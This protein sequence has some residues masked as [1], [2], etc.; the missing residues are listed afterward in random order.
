M[1]IEKALGLACALVT[2]NCAIFAEDLQP[3][4]LKGRISNTR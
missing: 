4:G 1:R 2:I 3:V